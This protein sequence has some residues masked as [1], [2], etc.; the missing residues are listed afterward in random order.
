M[1]FQLFDVSFDRPELSPCLKGLAT[2]STAYAE[3]LGLIRS[4]Q[5]SLQALPRADMSGFVPCEIDRK[6]QA[7]S[8]KY[9]AV[10]RDA[11]QAIREKRKIMDSN[12][13]TPETSGL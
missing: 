1:S 6:R 2:N 3:A 12:T 5:K 8:E 4:G 11:R 9:Q 13:A 10:E 7:H